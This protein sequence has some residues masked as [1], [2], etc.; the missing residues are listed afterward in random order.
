MPAGRPTDY[1]PEYCEAVIEHMKEGASLTS[2]AASVNCARSTINEWCDKNPEFS[3]AVKAAKA[4]CATWW[5]TQG[6]LGATGQAN[7]NPTLVIFGLKNMAGEDWREKQ[8][9]NHTSSD[10]SMS[11]TRIELVSPTNDNSSD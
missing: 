8:D 3:E 11:P 7:V 6:R 1:R 5:E 10:G 4:H 2:F 9:V